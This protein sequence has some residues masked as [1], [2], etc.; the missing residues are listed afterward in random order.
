MN[1]PV[2]VSHPFTVA[3]SVPGRISSFASFSFPSFLCIVYS[4]SSPHVSDSCGFLIDAEL[5]E[6]VP[7]FV[8]LE[9]DTLSS[10][11]FIP[12]HPSPSPS[13]D[14]P[15][16]LSNLVWITGL[17]Y[18]LLNVHIQYA[19]KNTY[20]PVDLSPLNST[21]EAVNYVRIDQPQTP[22]PNQLLPLLPQSPPS[23]LGFRV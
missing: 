17:G 6:V 18:L 19:Y 21:K 20:T 22:G 11:P 10:R 2:H 8:I 15:P 3:L 4:S 14:F 12:F 1:L 9:V 13:H 5:G 7:R 16:F 23:L